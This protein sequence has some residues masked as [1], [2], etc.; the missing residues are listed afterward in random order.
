MESYREKAMTTAP[1][2]LANSQI[3]MPGIARPGVVR[4]RPLN[5]SSLTPGQI[6][7]Y[8]GRVRGGPRFGLIGTVVETRLR[9]A[10]VDLGTDGR[11]HIPYYLLSMPQ[12]E[13]VFQPDR[14]DRRAAQVA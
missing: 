3:P 10:V 6:V 9:Q 4:R 12:T 1:L 13:P 14:A 2:D 7:Q 5:A 11:W 8:H